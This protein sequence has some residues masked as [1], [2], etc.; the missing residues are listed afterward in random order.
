MA[1]T[2]L[3][4]AGSATPY[5]KKYVLVG[6]GAEGRRSLLDLAIDLAEGPLKKTLLGTPSTAIDQFNIDGARGNEI[7][8]YDATTMLADVAA[9]KTGTRRIRWL[10]DLS[11]AVAGLSC[12]VA[13]GTTVLIEIR[14]NHSTQA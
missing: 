8:I 3:P 1:T 14:L 12:T 10:Q 7:R 13:A 5:S 9:T 4:I 2:I 6:D 11:S